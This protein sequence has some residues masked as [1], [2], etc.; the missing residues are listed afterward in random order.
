[1]AGAGDQTGDDG[2]PLEIEARGF[3]ELLNHVEFRKIW[4][5][6]I[7]SQLADKFL[8]YSLLTVTYQRSGANTQEAVVLLAYTTPSV[9][10]SP[11]AGV[12]ADRYPNVPPESVE[13]LLLSSQ[14][15]SR[16]V[17]VPVSMRD[18]AAGTPS[19]KNLKLAYHY[20]R[21][22]LSLLSRTPIRRDVRAL[23]TKR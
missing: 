3:K 13:A 23:R 18:R 10:L 15:G 2:V 20:L 22:L 7:A 9:L 5:S 21:A 12:Y 11:I 19:T 6:Q 4:L 8:V 14:A 1:M 16:V 17:E